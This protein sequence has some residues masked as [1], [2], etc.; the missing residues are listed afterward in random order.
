MS[1][2]GVLMGKVALVTGA[3]QGIGR[4]IAL[5]FAGEGAD[6]A[7]A[8]LSG[9]RAKDTAAEICHRGR[10]AL[11][12]DGDVSRKP[13]AEGWVQE[14]VAQLG[15]LDILVNCAGYR[16]RHP[17]LTFPEDE[18]DRIIAVCLKGTFLCAQAAAREMV[19]R[20][21]GRII[22]IS[23][24]VAESATVHTAA[25]TAAKGGVNSLT[26]VTATE[27]A[28]Y[29]VTVNAIAP[30]TVDTPHHLVDKTEADLRERLSR[31][32]LG[33]LGRPDEIAALALYLASDD[34]GW[35][36]GSVFRIDG[37]FNA[38]RVFPERA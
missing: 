20:Q 30:G 1:V 38:A 35:V 19:K 4:A 14:T 15:Q 11:A 9:T 18:M 26:Y 2:D 5:T 23:S 12:L 3:G 28:P 33:R 34:A 27:L 29:G 22:N 8:D 36:T 13:D 25:Y 32:P 37:G 10:R 31:T 16:T 7:A 6:V 24:V 21:S 17:F